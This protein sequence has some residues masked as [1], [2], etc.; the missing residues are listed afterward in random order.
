MKAADAERGHHSTTLPKTFQSDEADM[1][2]WQLGGVTSDVVMFWQQTDYQ[3][4]GH[5][6]ARIW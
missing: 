1:S 5:A 3:V 6:Q 2:G 4:C